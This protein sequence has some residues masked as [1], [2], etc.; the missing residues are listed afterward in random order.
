MGR[1]RHKCERKTPR[2]RAPAQAAQDLAPRADGH[3]LCW[4]ASAGMTSVV[5]GAVSAVADTSRRRDSRLIRPQAEVEL[6]VTQD[7]ANR[8]AAAVV[9][10]EL[11]A[12]SFPL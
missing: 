2:C 8:W 3:G 4:R 6:G 12:V 1:P 9:A 11:P 7:V 5:C 10:G